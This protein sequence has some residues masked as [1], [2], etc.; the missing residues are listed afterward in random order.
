MT[1]PNY[2]R[3]YENLDWTQNAFSLVLFKM[4]PVV[5]YCSSQE[6]H[7]RIQYNFQ[8]LWL[9]LFLSLVTGFDTHIILM[10]AAANFILM[11]ND[12]CLAAII[13]LMMYLTMPNS[14]SFKWKT[15]VTVFTR[16]PLCQCCSAYKRLNKRLNASTTTLFFL[17]SLY[18]FSLK[19]SRMADINIV[20]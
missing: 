14:R 4:K 8:I 16:F 9:L 17:K 20:K 2:V 10:Y 5:C 15:L 7:S 1:V 13:W 3:D 12:V 6:I 19:R 11:T 18:C